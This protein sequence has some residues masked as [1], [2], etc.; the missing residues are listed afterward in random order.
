MR[1]YAEIHNCLGKIIIV[2]ICLKIAFF[3]MRV[4]FNL[5]LVFRSSKGHC[6]KRQG[7]AQ[8]RQRLKIQNTNTRWSTKILAPQQRPKFNEELD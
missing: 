7:R 1:N 4:K 8:R 6:C 5:H 2:S 3:S